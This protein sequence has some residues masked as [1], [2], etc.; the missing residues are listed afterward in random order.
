MGFIKLMFR[1]LIFIFLIRKVVVIMKKNIFVFSE[2]THLGGWS[3]FEYF[4]KSAV[5]S[6][7]PTAVSK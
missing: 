1:I 5:A 2:N 7:K 4:K 3:R 6:T